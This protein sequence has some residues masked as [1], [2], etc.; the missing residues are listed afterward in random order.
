MPFNT[1][2]HVVVWCEILLSIHTSMNFQQD[3]FSWEEQVVV[4]V[5]P[6]L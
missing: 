6:E 5:A 2:H 3:A 1:E 4:I